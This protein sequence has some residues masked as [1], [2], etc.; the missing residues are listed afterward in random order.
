MAIRVLPEHMINVIAAG[1]VIERPASVVKELLENAIDA[2]ASQISVMLENAGKTKIVVNDNGCGISPQDLALAIERHATSKLPGDDLSDVA[3]LGFRGEALPSIG[4]IAKLTITSRMAGAEAAWQIEV[5]GGK[6]SAVH[7]ASLNPGTMVEVGDIFFATPARLKFLKS[8]ATELAHI[9]DIVNRLALIAPKIGF[10]VQHRERSLLRYAKIQDNLLGTDLYQPRV[11]QVIGQEF[12][13]NS[14]TVEAQREELKLWGFI[15]LPTY[16]RSNSQEQYFFVNNRPVRD[17]Q[18]QAAIRVAYQDVLPHDRYPATILYL[19]MPSD[20]LDVNVHP[21]KTE[22][23]FR[24]ADRVR[25]LIISSLRSRLMQNDVK[26]AN[27][28]GQQAIDYFKP[29]AAVQNPGLVFAEKAPAQQ[30]SW[31]ASRASFSTQDNTFYP[32]Q[33]NSPASAPGSSTL[34]PVEPEYFLGRA[35]AQIHRTYIVAQ[36]EE[37]VVIVDQH[38][39]HERLIYEKMKNGLQAEGVKRQALLIPEVVNL[40]QG[41]AAIFIEKAAEL[42]KLGLTIEPF[43]V[44]AV[45]VREIPALLGREDI[46]QTILDLAEQ[47]FENGESWII[48]NHLNEICGTLACHSSIRAGRTLSLNEMDALLRQMEQTPNSSQCNHGRP[49]YIELKREDMEKLFGRR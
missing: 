48:Q 42:S 1:E 28:I 29:N 45:L 16:H 22:V 26:T 38:A 9:I 10:S 30:F 23:R 32:P 41:R 3:T 20:Q 17:R 15:G 36:T 7:P 21:A 6:K 34:S 5:H 13:S 24:Q 33:D 19:E 18:L 39:A 27:T 4:A 14:L 25:S 35:V 31:N 43:G 2:G 12:I 44:D 46:T 47:I 37:K 8:D 40:P 49:T 11:L